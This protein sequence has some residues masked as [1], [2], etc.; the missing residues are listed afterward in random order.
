MANKTVKVLARIT[1]RPDK[2][3]E[4]RSLLLDL[5]KETRKEKGCISYQLLHG[6]ADPGDFTFVEEWEDDSVI[7]THFATAH[8]QDAFSKAASLI[9]KEPDIRRY[10]VIE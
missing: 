3:E 6:K 4:L 1:A 9:A 2:I 7:D 8:V 5:V 10:D